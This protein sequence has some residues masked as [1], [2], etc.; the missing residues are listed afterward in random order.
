MKKCFT[1]LIA[2]GTRLYS[3]LYVIATSEEEARQL[4]EQ[5]LAERKPL[6][7]SEAEIRRH[8]P[9]RTPWKPGLRIHFIM[10]SG[11]VEDGCKIGVV[12]ENEQEEGQGIPC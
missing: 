11:P 10:D 3:H 6:G 2:R 12:L 8:N 9:R 7:F 5:H 4:V 1:A